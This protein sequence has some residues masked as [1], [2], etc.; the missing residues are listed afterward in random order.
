MKR[1]MMDLR[2]DDDIIW[3][4]SIIAPWKES[5]WKNQE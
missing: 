1:G 2:V 5:V 3:N 4:S